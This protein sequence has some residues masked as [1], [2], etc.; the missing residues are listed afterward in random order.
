MNVP[1]RLPSDERQRGTH[2]QRYGVER[3]TDNDVNLQK[4]HPVV[5]VAVVAL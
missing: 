2:V 3:Y 5:R 1:K 4:H